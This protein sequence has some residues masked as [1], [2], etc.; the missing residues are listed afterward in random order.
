MAV[1]VL[2]RMVLAGDLWNDHSVVGMMEM[3]AD[4]LVVT[5]F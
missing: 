2:G 4:R 3:Y 5:G 1:M